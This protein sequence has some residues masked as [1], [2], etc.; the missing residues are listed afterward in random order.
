MENN[1]LLLRGNEFKQISRKGFGGDPNINGHVTVTMDHL[2]KLINKLIQIREFWNNE[3]VVFDGI[4]ISVYYNKIAAKSNRISTIFKG[5]HSNDFIVGNKYNEQKNK[6]I[7]T[8]HITKD[9]LNKTIELCVESSKVLKQY[10]NSKINKKIFKEKKEYI[11][12]IDYDNSLKNWKIFIGVIADISYV[13]TFDVELAKKDVNQHMITLYDVKQDLKL[14]LRKLGIDILSTRIIGNHTIFLEKNQL[15]LLYE[16]APYLVSMSTVDF[17]N[18]SPDDF[19]INSEVVNCKIE[20]PTNQPTIGVIDTLFDKKVYFNKWVEYHDLI[21]DEIKKS[22]KD[23]IHGTS[24]TSIIVD[25]CRL[26]N[27]LDD[28]CGRF[29]VRHFGVSLSDG[30]SSFNIIKNIKEIVKANKDIR[31]WNISLGTNDEVNENFIS[32]EASILDEIQFEN[33]VIFVISGTNNHTKN[34]RRIGSPADSINSLV[35]NSVTQNKKIADYTRKGTVLSFFTKPDVCYYGG[36]DEKYINAIGPSGKIEVSGTSYAA[37]WIARKLSYLI[38]VLGFNREIAK[39][40][41]IDSARGWNWEIS[42]E[43]IAYYGHGVVPIHIN[44]ILK[45]KKD[46]IKFMISDISEKWNSYNYN[47]PIPLNDD[48]Y[49]FVAKATMCYFPKCNRNQGVD[50]TNTELNLHFGRIDDENKIADI[51]GDKQNNEG[52]SKTSY[53]HEVSARND[54][55]K[56]DN[57]KCKIE[58]FSTR[59][60]ER[61]SYN[62][63]KWG[64][65]IKTSNRLDSNDGKGIRFGVVVTLKDI[66]GRNRID[67]FV[68]NFTL[69]SWIVDEIDIDK[70]I[71]IYEKNHEEI[72]F[73]TEDLKF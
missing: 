14:L 19:L 4:L 26:N 46:E 6:H 42:D 47:F 20:D 59:T 57:V 24:V 17:A 60:R 63:K 15:D 49:S 66:H 32:V 16:K 25:G 52:G 53:V 71:N 13:D 70:K 1:I 27:W 31:V 69:N 21:S 10:L 5:Q 37:P 35:V 22:E 28:G 7:T 33:N 64:M 29:K 73:E 36:S 30:F 18:L 41:I 50:Y 67:E 58:K 65:E 51:A 44:D 9:D 40:L 34:I 56:W 55:R 45:T 3:K 11:K 62:N 61:K 48:K 39:A 2:D 23:Y 54:F 38:D 12:N 8:Y 68:R 72:V 43:E